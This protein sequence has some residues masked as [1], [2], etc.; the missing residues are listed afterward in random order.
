MKTLLAQ[1]TNPVI[2]PKF[3]T[4]VGASDNPLASF[5]VNIWRAMVLF[6]ALLTLVYLLWASIDWLTSEGDAEKLKA[7]RSKLMNAI[8]GMGLLAASVAIVYLIDKLGILGFS[9]LKLE[10]P[11]P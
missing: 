2:N 6:G 8:V 3:G 4:L 1:I 7:A 10:W 11:T 5:F 9:L